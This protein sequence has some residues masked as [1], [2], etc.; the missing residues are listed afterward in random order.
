MRGAQGDTV[1]VTR[2]RPTVPSLH[3]APTRSQSRA[4]PSAY[5]SGGAARTRHR[6]QLGGHGATGSL[7]H[8]LNSLGLGGF[9][10]TAGVLAAL[11]IIWRAVR[12]PAM[13]PQ[14]S[15]GGA[16]SGGSGSVE[17]SVVRYG[18]VNWLGCQWQR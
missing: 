4:A 16:Q 14:A 12:G 6:W 10:V 13:P 9:F 7:G 5:L 8:T 11:R 2:P 15:L 18:V 1:V 3:R 17:F